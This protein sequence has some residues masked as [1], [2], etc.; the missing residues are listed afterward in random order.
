MFE[1]GIREVVEERKGLFFCLVYLYFF[2]EE[3]NKEKEKKIKVKIFFFIC[4]I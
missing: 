2:W 1:Y 3:E 4:D